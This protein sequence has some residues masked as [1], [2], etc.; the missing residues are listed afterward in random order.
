MSRPAAAWNRAP[1]Q[2][3][4]ELS[5]ERYAAARAKGQT[6]KAA[7]EEAGLVYRT[8]LEFEKNPDMKRRIQ[9]LRQ[10]SETFVGYSVAFILSEL[11]RNAEIA[12]EEKQ[13]KSSNEALMA[14]Y[15][16][17]S[18][19]PDAVQ[20][21]ARALPPDLDQKTV[22]KEL[23]ASLRHE[24]DKQLGPGDDP[25]PGEEAPDEGDD[26]DDQEDDGDQAA[27]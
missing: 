6:A 21:A 18:Q 27:E 16:I 12:R 24:E 26:D 7:A 17:I 23:L 3:F 15:K 10:H 20:N 4:E 5:R 9:E 19:D 8:G 13:I 14:M 2:P 25:D 22:R 1:G 11:K